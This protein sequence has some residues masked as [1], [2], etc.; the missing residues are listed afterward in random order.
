MESLIKQKY[1]YEK[2]YNEYSLKLCIPY[3]YTLI[4]LKD[5]TLL[6]N[7]YYK[8]N[9]SEGKDYITIKQ[10]ANYDLLKYTNLIRRNWGNTP[11]KMTQVIKSIMNILIVS[12]SLIE[13]I[14]FEDDFYG[15][16][17]S[18]ENDLISLIIEL[19]L[20]FEKILFGYMREYEPIVYGVYDGIA[21]SNNV[22]KYPHASEYLAGEIF[23]INVNPHPLAN[24]VLVENQN[25]RTNRVKN[26]RST[27]RNRNNQVNRSRRNSEVNLNRRNN[28]LSR[29]NNEV[30]LNEVNLNRRN[31]QLSRRNNEVNLN[32]RNNQVNRRNNQVNRRNNQLSRRNNQLS[33]RNNEVNLNDNNEV[34]RRNNEV[35][36][37]EVNLNEVNLNRRNN[38][39]NLNEVNLNEVNLNRR[40]NEVNLN[41]VNLNEVNLNDNN[42]V[43]RRTI[44]PG[45][46]F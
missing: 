41:E 5:T 31:N 12:L 46:R 43:S 6:Y 19:T 28:Q 4:R 1:L 42:E 32:R 35:N 10:K 13:D 22:E 24:A 39:V 7:I 25:I 27:R 9:N 37:N 44:W 2:G 36:L 11:E 3:I 38:E 16:I 18:C 17:L 23:A 8:V 29:R 33:R 40:N 20:K 26:A 45:T 30:N 15:K 34:S 14:P 21:S